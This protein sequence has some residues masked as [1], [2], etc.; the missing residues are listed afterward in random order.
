MLTAYCGVGHC[1]RTHSLNADG[2]VTERHSLTEWP[3]APAMPGFEPRSADVPRT[4]EVD[5]W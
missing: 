4:V 2:T 1:D 5:A 3:H